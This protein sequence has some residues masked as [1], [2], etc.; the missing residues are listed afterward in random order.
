M[1][2][3]VRYAAMRGSPQPALPVVATSKA[4]PNLK[5]LLLGV[6]LALGMHDA[7]AAAWQPAG[8]YKQGDVVAHQGQEWQA[9]WWTSGDTPGAG[10]IAWQPAPPE[11]AAAWQ[12]GRA[13][14]AGELTAFRG[15]LYQ[16]RWWTRGETPATADGAWRAL[17]TGVN[18][19]QFVR[20]AGGTF[21]MGATIAGPVNYPNEYPVHPVTL[22]PF[23]LSATEVTYRQFDRY[24]RA[25]GQSPLSSADLGGVDMGRGEN[26]A[27]NVTWWAAIRYVNWL[28]QRKGWP[29]AYDEASGDLLDAAGRPT[30]DVAKVIGYRLPTEAE[31]EYAAR[32]RG[33]DIINAWGNGAPLINGKPAANIADN[34]FKVYFEA[35]FNAPL[36]SW[37]VPWE[38][39]DGHIRLAPVGSFVP[40]SLGLYDMSGSAWEWTS[41]K[42]RAFTTQPQTNPV[43]VGEAPG[44]I[45]RGASWDNGQD[46]HITDRYAGNPAESTP[47]TGLRLARSVIPG[48]HDTDRED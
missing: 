36:P 14:T 48:R 31:W 25:T 34:D 45:M 46:M 27:V 9:R 47:A 20:V 13:Y 18:G 10:S 42:E 17:G 12:S 3:A 7:F 23:W 30:V 33:Q 37:V 24:T 38:V 28:N 43:G 39:S 41:D 1:N 26:P 4:R 32:D 22:S 29:K 8:A 40:N 15:E 16:A 6:L 5:P 21:I 19:R 35:L 44:R 2:Q 11:N